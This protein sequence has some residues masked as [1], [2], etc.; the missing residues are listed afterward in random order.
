VTIIGL[1]EVLQRIIW[2]D[3]LNNFGL[4]TL[5]FARE[6]VCI[7]SDFALRSGIGLIYAQ[8]HGCRAADS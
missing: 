3:L 1:I 6:P 8:A 5:S 2:I 7:V 4:L